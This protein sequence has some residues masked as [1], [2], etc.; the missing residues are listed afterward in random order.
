MYHKTLLCRFMGSLYY[1][2][3]SAMQAIFDL[4][5]KKCILF[6]GGFRSQY[7]DYGMDNTLST[8][9]KNCFN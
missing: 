2:I 1:L 6:C 4:V 5:M 7:Y 9:N 3:L 8:V